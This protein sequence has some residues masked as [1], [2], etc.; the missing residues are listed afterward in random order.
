MLAWTEIFTKLAADSEI[1]VAEEI[2]AV[3]ELEV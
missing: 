3:S 1:I 2:S